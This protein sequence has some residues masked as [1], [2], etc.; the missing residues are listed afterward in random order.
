MP[1]ET[2][3]HKQ[4]FDVLTTAKRPIFISD[5]RVDGD[6]LGSS[7][8]LA[9]W[10]RTRGKIVPVY[11]KDGVPA[12]YKKLPRVDQCT[13][14][15]AVFATSLVDVVVTFDCSDGAYVNELLAIMP[16]RPTVI[17]IDHHATNPRYGDINQ[18][19]V[20]APATAEVV[21]RFFKANGIIPTR[22]AAT[23]LLAGICFDTSAFSNG[24]TN[25]AAFESASELLLRGGSA[26]DMIRTLF[27]DRSVPTLRLWGIA[28]ER[29][30]EHG[31]GF[32]ST[33]LSKAD[34]DEYGVSEEDVE[35]LSNFLSLVIQTQTLLVL[36][37]TEDGVKGSLRS[38]NQDVSKVAKYFGGGGHIRAAGF[39][40]P[41]AKVG[42]SGAI[43]GFPNFY[44]TI[45][46]TLNA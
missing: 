25:R 5:L 45:A 2:L 38:I 34:L 11:V 10:M 21:H 30:R 7:L 12:K 1:M 40:L 14:D 18:V 6:S 13:S 27:F 39:T 9:D 23:L 24:A 26:Q 15:Q 20:G 35:G 16:E 19:I 43:E 42:D 17:N 4:I 3:V 29:L 22:E 33:H 37:E 32:V 28:L 41:L 44:A 31:S 46:E 8:A 36:R